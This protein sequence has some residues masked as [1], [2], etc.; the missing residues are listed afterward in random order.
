M[1]FPPSTVRDRCTTVCLLT[2]WALKPSRDHLEHAQ[3]S[4]SAAGA[5]FGAPPRRSSLLCTAV[6][7]PIVSPTTLMSTSSSGPT[8]EW[9]S[10]QD[11]LLQ[12]ATH[13]D[14]PAD[15]MHFSC[16]SRAWRSVAS[17]PQLWRALLARCFG[18][19]AIQLSQQPAAAS[20]LP[21]GADP[22]ATFRDLCTLHGVHALSG[23]AED[24]VT[25]HGQPYAML[26]H[27][28]DHGSHVRPSILYQR[29]VDG[30]VRCVGGGPPDPRLRRRSRVHVRAHQRR[31]L[32][33]IR[34]HA[35]LDAACVWPAAAAGGPTASRCRAP[36]ASSSS[37]RRPRRCAARPCRPP[38]CQHAPRHPHAKL[39]TST[40]LLSPSLRSGVGGGAAAVGAHR[41]GAA[42]RPQPAALQP[43]R[44]HGGAGEAARQRPRRR[45]LPLLLLP[46][47]ARTARHLHAARHCE[48]PRSFC[49]RHGS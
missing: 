13:L 42:G 44:P 28:L 32:A 27:D 40:L 34:A 43:P 26:V 47:G 24:H 14:D 5:R 16:V 41:H 4:F 39:L 33:R 29:V 19:R 36:D 49:R 35:T 25:L 30:C 38:P 23:W 12:I 15:L 6:L 17:S 10:S 18:R 20:G 7:A 1:E 8:Q 46:S 21:R 37:T 45:A 9:S 22:R 31:D 2:A 48:R 3:R 11:V